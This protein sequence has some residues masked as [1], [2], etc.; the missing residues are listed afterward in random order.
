ME[1]LNAVTTTRP[2]PTTA[3]LHSLRIGG[4]HP[5]G[6]LRCLLGVFEQCLAGVALLPLLGLHSERAHDVG[7]HRGAAHGHLAAGTWGGTGSASNGTEVT[8]YRLHQVCQPE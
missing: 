7:G 2:R 5:V 8:G 3:E 6:V 4:R 1:T